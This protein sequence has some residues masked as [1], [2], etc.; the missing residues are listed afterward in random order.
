[1]PIST[2][3]SPLTLRFDW[4]CQKVL[5]LVYDESL[6]YYEVLCKLTEYIKEMAQS[7]DNITELSNALNLQ[8]Q[9]ISKSWPDLQQQI[10]ND[11]N[12]FK[13]QVTAELQQMSD[14]LDSIKN[15][16]YV[17]LYLNSIQNYIDNNLA[18]IIANSV[19][20][21]QFG[22]NS[23]G[24][25]VVYIPKKWSFLRFG[26]IENID[27]DLYGHLILGVENGV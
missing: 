24:Y 19:N 13:E 7:V 22:I 3:L 18:E 14:V 12:A 23:A 15:G 6:S 8:V 10:I 16:D 17:D 2:P 20:F 25:F 9:D 4:W 27:S 26:T 1:M 21:V 11:Q 5:P